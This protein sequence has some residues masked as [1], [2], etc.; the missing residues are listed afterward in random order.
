[1]DIR[2]ANAATLPFDDRTF[3]LALTFTMFSSIPDAA[4]R[5]DVATEIRRVLR[6]RGAVLWYDFWTNPVNADVKALRLREIERLFGRKAA[7][8]R[9]VTLAPPI[10]RRVAPHS[11]L[12]CELLT[13]IPFLRTHWLAIVRL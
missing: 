2:V 9:R 5:L 4:L 13:A 3:D 10:S 7:E 8:A 1:M 11:L 6:P 12:A